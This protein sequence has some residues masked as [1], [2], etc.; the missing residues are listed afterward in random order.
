[1]P[2]PFHRVN[3]ILVVLDGEVAPKTVVGGLRRPNIRASDIVV[4]NQRES[5]GEQKE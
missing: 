1:M 4:L 2:P 3:L 5:D